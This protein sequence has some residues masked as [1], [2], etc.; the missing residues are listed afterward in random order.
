M[1]VHLIKSTD[2]SDAAIFLYIFHIKLWILKKL[3]WSQ[4][5]S[6]FDNFWTSTN[7]IERSYTV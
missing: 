2:N 1:R 3:F 7:R 6:Y 5:M 4:F